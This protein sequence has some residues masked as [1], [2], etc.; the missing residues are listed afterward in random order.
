[1]AQS[2]GSKGAE[3]DILI[4]QGATFGPHTCTLT[5]PNNT[6]V[7]LTGSTIRGALRKCVGDVTSIGITPVIVITDALAGRFTWEFTDE[8]T[9]TLTADSISESSPDSLYSYDI[10]MVDVSGRV[11]PLLY[12]T[13]RVFRDVQ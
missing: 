8:D 7:N 11:I 6:P 5:N 13:A 12:G 1:M 2:I 3:L 10:E 9:A 4:R